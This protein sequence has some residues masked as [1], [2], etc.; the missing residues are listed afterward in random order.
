MDTAKK[1]GSVECGDLSPLSIS[2]IAGKK[3]ARKSGDKSP[4]LQNQDT[5]KKP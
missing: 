2:A 4:A 3:A 1:P 5:A